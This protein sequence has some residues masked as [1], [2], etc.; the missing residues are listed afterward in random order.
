V[1]DD[2]YDDFDNQKVVPRAWQ[3]FPRGDNFYS[4]FI[5]VVPSEDIKKVISSLV[6]DINF[7]LLIFFYISPVKM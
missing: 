2:N 1:T 3:E 7:I 5:K 6:K 4:V